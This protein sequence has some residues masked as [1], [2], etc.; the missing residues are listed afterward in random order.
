LFFRNTLTHGA[1]LAVSLVLVLLLIL[2]LLSLARFTTGLHPQYGIMVVAGIG[3][4][5]LAFVRQDVAAVGLIFSMILSPEINV[6]SLPGREVVIRFD[7]ILV[8]IFFFS[9]LFK[10]AYYKDLGVLRVTPLNIPIAAYIL[11]ALLS[12]ARAAAWGRIN[13]INSLFYFLKYVEYFMIFFMFSNIIKTEEQLGRYIKAFLLAAA[14]V[15]IYGVW[16]V[17][18]GVSR[19]SAPFEGIRGEANTYGGYLLLVIGLTA[20]S[21]LKA[22]TLR[23]RLAYTAATAALMALLVAT[24][25]RASYLGLFMLGLALVPFIRR[26]ERRMLIIYTIILLVVSPIFLPKKAFDRMLA[27]FRG[28]TEQVLPFLNLNSEDSSY[29]KI[30]T[31]KYIVSL[32]EHYPVLGRGITGVGLVDSQYPRILGEMGI[33]GVLCFLW[34]ITAIFK[35]FQKAMKSLDGFPERDIWQWRSVVAGYIAA[36]AGLLVHAVGAN[37]FIIVRI[38]E[39]FWF[40]TAIVVAIPA[41]MESKKNQNSG[42]T[43]K[44]QPVFPVF[45]PWRFREY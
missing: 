20:M 8:V 37:T 22:P 17:A 12:S 25:S 14:A 18:N 19:I 23:P 2:A 38:M 40:L 33:A 4:A 34:I 36:L 41:V 44:A 39:P 7:D 45:Q 9:W 24:Y 28:D 13:I 16:Q 1:R 43:E 3:F 42:K 26:R 32:W 15:S 11:I 27:P 6:A 5:I 31:A 29:Y 21:A 10:M 30:N 35:S